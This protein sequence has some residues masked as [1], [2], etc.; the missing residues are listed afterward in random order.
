MHRRGER[1]D[2]LGLSG[3]PGR[4]GW[5]T[6]FMFENGDFGDKTPEEVEAFFQTWL[7][8]GLLM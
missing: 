7:Y 1:Y 8:F 4:K 2:M 6:K 5:E 3:C